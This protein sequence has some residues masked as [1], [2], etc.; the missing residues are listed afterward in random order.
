MIHINCNDQI[1]EISPNTTLSQFLENRNMNV[2]GGV[3]VAV[4]NQVVAKDRWEET[5]LQ[6]NDHILIIGAYYGG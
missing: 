1:L 2:Q 6:E 3:A 5:I 4:N